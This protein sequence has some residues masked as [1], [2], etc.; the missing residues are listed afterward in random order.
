MTPGARSQPGSPYPLKF[1]VF[2]Q[3]AWWKRRF[4]L[5]LSEGFFEFVEERMQL[6]HG[7]LVGITWTW[8]T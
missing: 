5:S 4:H 3:E 6:E 2:L 1:A 8:L 7:H